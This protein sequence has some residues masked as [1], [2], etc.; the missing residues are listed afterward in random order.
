MGYEA[1]VL[2]DQKNVSIGRAPDGRVVITGNFDALPEQTK[3]TVQP[4]QLVIIDSHEDKAHLEIR[5]RPTVGALAATLA[6][7]CWEDANYED[8]AR[9]IL[10]VLRIK[11]R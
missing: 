1:A 7:V 2:F 5:N 3:I 11:P 4:D 10:S 8:V 9:Q 6:G